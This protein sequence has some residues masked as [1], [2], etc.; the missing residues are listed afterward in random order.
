MEKTEWFQKAV[1]AI[2][3]TDE[4]AA[5]KIAT[6]SLEAGMAPL[7]MINQGFTEGIRQM[8]DLFERGE[9]FLPGLIVASEAMTAAV[10]ILEAALPADQ[11]AAKKAVI[12]LGTV[13]GDIH[14][15]GIELFG[16]LDKIVYRHIPAYIVDVKSMHP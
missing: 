8:G 11:Q 6:E 7:E 16:L 2:M 5:K 15:I 9:V 14:D 10:V 4:E 13:E 1:Q 12:V 3:D